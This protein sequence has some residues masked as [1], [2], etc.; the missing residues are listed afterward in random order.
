MANGSRLKRLEDVFKFYKYDEDMDLDLQDLL[1]H[2][3]EA[4]SLIEIRMINMIGDELRYET[5]EGRGLFVIAIGGLALSR[6][7]TLEGLAVS[8]IIRN[9]GAK[10]TLLQTARWFGYRPDY[11][12]LCRILMPNVLV[13][14]FLETART[15]EELR[16]DLARMVEVGLTPKEFGLRVRHSGFGLA[17]T[18]SNKRGTGRKIR[19][20]D[21]FERTHYQCAELED[22][23]DKEAKKRGINTRIFDRCCGSR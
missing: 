20:G 13:G 23:P 14:R 8:Y 6:G 5:I 9:V 18:A 15:V 7:L 17:I 10:D 12:N 3:R 4:I 11:E 2:L 1:P 19:V 21:D 22:D 16:S